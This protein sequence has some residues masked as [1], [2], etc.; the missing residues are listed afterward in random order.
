[1]TART[2]IYRCG[3]LRDAAGTCLRPGT[4]AVCNDKIVSVT[5][6]PHPPEGGRDEGDAKVTVVDLPGVLV[7][8]AM[9]NAHTHLDITS[10]GPEP[11]GG[12]FLEWVARIVAW[13]QQ[14]PD[15]AAK[16]VDLGVEM[17][18]SSGVG[19]VGD[20]AGSMDSALAFLA[21]G[22][23]GVS[24]IECFGLGERQAAAIDAMHAWLRDLS[25]RASES[26]GKVGIQPHAPYSAGEAVYEA[27]TTAARQAHL[28]LCTHLAETPE[29]LQFVRDAAGPLADRLKEWGK[30]DDTIQ[31]WH[32]HPV[33]WLR[34]QLER[35]PWLLAHCNYMDDQHIRVL[36]ECHSSVAYCPVASDYFRHRPDGHR[37]LQMLDAG[38]NVCL[39]T[40]SILCQ[41]ADQQQPLGILPQMRHLYRRDGGGD[42]LASTLLEMA[43]VNGLK[44]LGLDPMLATFQDGVDAMLT[45]VRFDPEDPTDPL[46]QVLENDYPVEP[47][48]NWQMQE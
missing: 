14:H 8:P 41:P 12:D 18:K 26:R 40:D 11:Y 21:S 46:T 30:W 28:P 7:M 31:A 23:A 35:H 43:T 48:T 22:A 27:A 3:A 9:V 24:F 34:P 1:M 33:D 4:L 15:Q 6:L 17:S 42:A 5:P 47:I 38:V 36:A 39:G 19:W 20:I 32:V 13:R 2:T 44:A 45:G 25:E 10:I 29:E 37:Y 16:G